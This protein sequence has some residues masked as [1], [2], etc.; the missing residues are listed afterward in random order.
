MRDVGRRDALRAAGGVALLGG[1]SGCIAITEGD[2]RATPIGPG[3]AA[4]TGPAEE[5]VAE[6]GQLRVINAVPTPVDV[7]IDDDPVYGN[8]EF[9]RQTNY[10]RL[11]AGRQDMV[12]RTAG[13]NGETVFQGEFA[14]PTRPYTLVVLPETSEGGDESS[15]NVTVLDDGGDVPESRSRFRFLHAA[16]DAPPVSVVT[17][18]GRTIFGGVEFGQH[19]QQTLDP[20]TYTFR[21]RPADGGEPLA[22]KRMSIKGGMFIDLFALGFADGGGGSKPPLR[23]ERYVTASY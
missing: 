18:G 17:A 7:N 4:G 9:G 22:T 13:P 2:E 6:V 8:V 20:G 5:P 10:V 16:P 3:T 15:V 14:H 23:L 11:P 1:L 19:E 12:V 21:V